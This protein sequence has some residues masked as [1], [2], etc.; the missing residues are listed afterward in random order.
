[1]TRFFGFIVA[2]RGLI[3]ALA[4][5]L[6]I[7]GA[8]NLSGLSIDA[9]PDISPKQVMILT[10]AKGLGP[11]EV[12]RL[13]TFP[14]ENAMAGVP[15]MKSIRSTSRF[16]ISAVYITFKEAVSVENARAEVSERLTA[17][18]ATMPPGVGKPT[19]GPVA[20]GLG[21]VYQFELRGPG[22]TQMELH[23]ILEWQIA[24]KLKL[25]PGVTDVNIYGGQLETYEVRVAADALR[26]YK[27]TLAQVFDAVANNNETRGG[28]YIDRDQEQEVVRGI[29]LVKKLENLGEIVLATGPGGV[30]VKVSDVGSV[31]RAPMVRLGAVSHDGVG[32]TV[33]GV[34]LML[35]GDNAADVVGAIKTAVTKIQASL[36]P[37]VAIRPY[38]DRSALVDR[39]IHTVEH[40]LLEGALLVGFVLLVMLGNWRA[41]LIVAAA[42]PLSMLIAF[43]GMRSFGI[44]ANLM[45]LGAIDFGLIVDGAVVMVDNVLSRSGQAKGSFRETVAGAAAEVARPVFFAVL[46]IVIVYVP[47]LS[48]EGVAGKMFKPMAETVILALLGSLV[49]TMTVMPALAATALKPEKKKARETFAVRWL[50][51]GYTP[52]LKACTAHPVLI[53]VAAL[54]LFAGSIVLALGLGGEFIPQLSEGS[55]VVTSEKLPG[56]NLDASLRTVNEIEKVVGTFPEVKHIVSLTGSAAIPTDPMGVESTDSFISLTSPSTW[57]G[58][59]RTQNDLVSALDDKLKKEVPGVAFTFSQPIQMRMND[60]LQGVKAD[61]A[62]MIYG[63]DLKTLQQIADK[64]VQTVSGIKG[65]DDVKPEA[66]AG[67]S[68]LTISVDRAAVA[69]YGMNAKT[70]L[71]AVDAIGG[72]LS[73]MVYGEDN[74]ETQIMVRWP[75]GDRANIDRIRNLPVFDGSGRVVPLSTVAKVDVESG[76]AQISREALQRRTYVEI[77][78]RGRDAASFVK[79]AQTKVAQAVHLPPRYSI[80]WSGQYQN[81]QTADA[82]LSFV[83]PVAMAAILLL[84]YFM[85]DDLRLT[86][87]VFLLIPIS[88]SGGILALVA[89]GL[90]FSISAAIG[91]IAT[92]GIATLNGVVLVSYLKD[93][94]D[95][96]MSAEEAAKEAAERRMR[97]VLMTAFVATL[98]FLPMAVST[99]AG[100]EVQRPLATVVIGGLITAT[101][102]TLLVLPAIYPIADRLFRPAVKQK[103]ADATQRDEDDLR[104]AAE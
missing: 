38:Y 3:L 92:F 33:V 44:S 57:K 32:E 29:G 65:A 59:I 39:T 71:D 23:R 66:Q 88:A 100:A 93:E 15:D 11:L 43:A 73:G 60:L 63:D 31:V 90:P 2:R 1:M 19:M 35:Y 58:A 70:V 94:R 42:I 64:I 99:G 86:L 17:A 46:I 96:G 8:I 98:G 62:V 28:A 95:A 83:V 55:I 79:E 52:V 103:P 56:I 20:T 13:V 37:G 50:R 49:L 78:L 68:Y 25:V 26:R 40:N 74:S 4:A 41:A 21:E 84:L 75:P 85:F 82:R 76:P 67:M 101:I 6:A 22:Y 16:G 80:E 48:L 87:L 54:A 10:E 24:P 36:P 14:V 72:H 81:M 51:R 9:V 7:G 77:N 53:S 97:P 30:P 34:V 104:I 45:S 61:I 12:E 18:I 5:L 102:L 69:R 89:R 91:F 47:V 27:I